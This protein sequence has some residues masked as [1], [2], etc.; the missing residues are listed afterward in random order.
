MFRKPKSAGNWKRALFI[1]M[2]CALGFASCGLLPLSEAGYLYKKDVLPN[3]LR[4]DVST[5][6]R[7]GFEEND[8]T[9]SL[10]NVFKYHAL[11]AGSLDPLVSKSWAAEGHYSLKVPAQVEVSFKI[12][13][14]EAGTLSLRTSGEYYNSIL[15]DGAGVR[16][17]NYEGW[18][19][20]SNL[21]IFPITAG[22]HTILLPDS[23]TEIFFDDLRFDPLLVGQSPAEG[24]IAHPGFVL[25]WPDFPYTST[26]RLQVAMDEDFSDLVLDVDGL[27]TSR[28]TPTTLEKGKKYYWRVTTWRSEEFTAWTLPSYFLI[29]AAPVDESFENGLAG[30]EALNAWKIEGVIPPRIQSADAAEGSNS[31]RLDF[32]YNSSL[33]WKTSSATL[34]Y[35]LERPKLMRY[36]V[37]FDFDASAPYCTG[38]LGVEPSGGTPE[39]QVETDRQ[40]RAETRLLRQGTG[41]VTW[42]Y[43]ANYNA[44][45]PNPGDNWALIDDI[46]FEDIPTFT[47]DGFELDAQ[48]KPCFAWGFG[49]WKA[50]TILDMGGIGN[51]RCAKIPSSCPGSL[52]F[53]DDDKSCHL[54]LV[55]DFGSGP[56]ILKLKARY[57]QYD[58]MVSLL[59]D[60]QEAECLSCVNDLANPGWKEYSFSIHTGGPHE[61]TI[62]NMGGGYILVDDVKLTR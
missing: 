7:D 23:N 55:A 14:K 20:T 45:N 39:F 47:A 2:A 8:G 6:F 30:E 1:W 10:L 50:P 49:G 9:K 56:S 60:G 58:S 25:D 37:K 5:Y 13:P 44:G 41:T 11:S 33:E 4:G 51:S 38:I 57:T 42:E 34:A 12:C 24:D 62:R 40:W 35:T 26:Y 19:G 54:S 16:C 52:N 53:P 28:F 15:V 48:G 43:T 22:L 36:S 29:P 59:I 21:R 32:I 46:R 18:N 27:T 61:A 17:K 3:Y 31:L